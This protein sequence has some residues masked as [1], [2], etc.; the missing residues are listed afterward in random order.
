MNDKKNFEKFEKIKVLAMDVDGTLTN[1]QVFYSRNGE[2]L[3]A[4]SIRDGM[5]I[6]LLKLSGLIPM[7][8]TSEITEI[9]KARATKLKIEHVLLGSK[10]K[11]QDLFDFSKKIGLEL[12]N[13]AYIGDDINDLE[14]MKTVG[15]SACPNDAVFLIKEQVDYICSNT[16]GHG[17]VREFIEL[18]LVKQNKK[19][20]LPIN[21]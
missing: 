4:F 12:E 1:S 6:E 15:L 20:T 18:I 5:G 13:F 3:K 2:E 19:L 16:G 8:I 10:N 14:V 21:W 17:A 9:V 11:K 7:I